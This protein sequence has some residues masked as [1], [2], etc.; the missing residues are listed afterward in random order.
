MILKPQAP[1]KEIIIG[2]TEYPIPRIA[3]GTQSITPHIT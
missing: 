3:Y 2:V 1:I